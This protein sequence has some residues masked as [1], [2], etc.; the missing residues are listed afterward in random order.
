MIDAVL[1]GVAYSNVGVFVALFTAA[2]GEAGGGT[3]VSTVGT[4]YGRQAVTFIAPVNGATE[5]S[6][7]VTYVVA[8]AAWGTITH[9][10]IFDAVAAG[11]MLYHGALVTPRV[12]NAGDQAKFLAGALD[13]AEL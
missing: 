13:V 8:S 5:N 11:N 2:P 7:D 12:V 9:F 3:E 6:A 4:G 1:R 10:A